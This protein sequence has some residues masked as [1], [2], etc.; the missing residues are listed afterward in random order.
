M[1]GRMVESEQER[2]EETKQRRQVQ[3]NDRVVPSTW[4]I[5]SSTVK[6]LQKH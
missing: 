6:I 4:L 2:T 1:R 5:P 3:L